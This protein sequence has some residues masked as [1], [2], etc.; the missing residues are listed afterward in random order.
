MSSLKR[1]ADF[2]CRSCRSCSWGT[3][4]WK[5]LFFLFISFLFILPPPLFLILISSWHLTSLSLS[6][7]FSQRPLTSD[8]TLTLYFAFITSSPNLQLGCLMLTPPHLNFNLF[9]THVSSFWEFRK[10]KQSNDDCNHRA[11]LLHHLLLLPF[12]PLLFT[13]Q[14]PL[15]FSAAV[16]LQS[17]ESILFFPVTICDLL[18]FS[19]LS[20]LL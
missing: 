4:L 3:W 9:K 18:L 20:F 13:S 5:A 14:A 10:Q 11:T 8:L 16:S 17:S 6:L 15:I 7:P 1:R 19:Q 12:D 2:C